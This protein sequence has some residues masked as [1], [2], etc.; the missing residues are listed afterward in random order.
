[1]NTQ[2]TLT[3]APALFARVNQ[4]LLADSTP[5]NKDT[6]SIDWKSGDW[7]ISTLAVYYGKILIAQSTATLDYYNKDATLVNLSVRYKIP[8]SKTVI[9]F[10]ADNLFDQYP[11][12]LPANLRTLA[13]NGINTSS[14]NGGAVYSGRSPYGFNGRNVFVK[15]SQ[16]F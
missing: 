5:E 4:N 3:P 7:G 6:L 2:S 14:F 8:K 13:A 9:S 1:M 16:N 10:G 15:I 11:T 12:Q